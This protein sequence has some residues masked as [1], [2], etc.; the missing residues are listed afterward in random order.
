[1]A[2]IRVE[3]LQK[4]FG[5]KKVH[6]GISFELEEGESLTIIGGS[7]SGKSVLLKQIIGL[8][9]PDQGQIWIEGED[10]TK[11]D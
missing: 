10:I 7:G 11:L 2:M 1:M 4:S 8:I 3:G 5:R 6:N 9:K